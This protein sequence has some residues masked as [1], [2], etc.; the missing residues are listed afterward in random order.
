MLYR[1]LPRGEGVSDVFLDPRRGLTVAT[2]VPAFIRCSS[3]RA[4]PS[5]VLKATAVRKT[6]TTKKKRTEARDGRSKQQLRVELTAEEADAVWRPL[7]AAFLG[8][9]GALVGGDVSSF[10]L[11]N[12]TPLLQPPRMSE[13]VRP[14]NLQGLFDDPSVNDFSTVHVYVRVRP[15]GVGR[16]EGGGSRQLPCLYA[17]S[18]GRLAVTAP[19]GSSA[20]RSGDC[21]AGQVMAFNRVFGPQTSQVEYYMQ[22]AKALVEQ[23]V[24]RERYEGVFLVVWHHRS[25]QD[26]HHPGDQGKSR[27]HSSGAADAVWEACALQG[28]EGGAFVLRGLQ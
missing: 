9:E 1:R 7:G 28:D 24:Q 11:Q 23:L 20:H 10:S 2:A 22:T 21:Q 16:G 19:P 12:Q 8:G 13:E 15:D 25:G 18:S 14:V 5:S 27:R 6:A 17:A 3:S 4:L 26:V